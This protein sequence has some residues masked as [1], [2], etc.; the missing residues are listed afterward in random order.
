MGACRQ[1]HR[2]GSRTSASACPAGRPTCPGQAVLLHTTATGV[3]VCTAA[4]AAR[5]FLAASTSF[6]AA[7]GRVSARAL[8]SKRRVPTW[9]RSSLRPSVLRAAGRRG[10][11]GGAVGRQAPMGHVLQLPTTRRRKRGIGTGSSSSRQQQQA[12]QQAEHS[13]PVGLGHKRLQARVDALLALRDARLD[14]GKVLAR[15]GEAVALGLR[16]F[17][18]FYDEGV[19]TFRGF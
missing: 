13:S 8:M 7:L 18:G 6:L 15:L 17:P 5:T 12:H 19:V 16:G 1:S 2:A 11:V 10:R 14:Q 4:H 9:R 3:P